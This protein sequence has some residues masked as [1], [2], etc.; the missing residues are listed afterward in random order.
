MPNDTQAASSLLSFLSVVLNSDVLRWGVTELI[1]FWR[2]SRFRG[3]YKVDQYD[4][5]LE[6]V[7]GHG[8][9]ALFTKR[10]QVEFLQDGIVAVQ[11][12]AWGDGDI[13]VDYRCTPGVAVDRYIESN[14]WKILISLRA[15]KN[16]GDQETLAVERTIEQGFTAP[17]EH[18]QTQVDHPMRQLSMAV[19]FPPD[20]LPK[21]ITLLEQDAK[22]SR[23][24][25][26]STA[27]P[28]SR[29]RFC[30]Q[31]QITRPRLYEAYILKWDW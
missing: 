25:D 18:F 28:L 16:R 26:L 20:R 15:T 29:G 13:F 8:A 11:D 30:Y 19:I 14:R 6:L 27:I 21:Q 23:Q 7:D 5:T 10:Q 1:Q 2:A 4:T 9:V 17:T 24:V 31:W 3:V 22:R 12:Q